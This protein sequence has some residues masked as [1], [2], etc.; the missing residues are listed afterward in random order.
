MKHKLPAHSDT[1]CVPLTI[2]T[3]IRIGK[4]AHQ[5]IPACTGIGILRCV[6]AME[7]VRRRT[8]VKAGFLLLNQKP[9]LTKKCFPS[10]LLLVLFRRNALPTEAELASHV[11]HLFL[12][13][14]LYVVGLLLPV[15]VA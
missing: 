13:K 8:A 14:F 15:F 3:D 2:S 7:R 4:N 12:Y 5:R 6:A 9:K 10:T 11:G 1:H